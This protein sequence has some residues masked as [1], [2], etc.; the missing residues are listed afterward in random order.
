MLVLKLFK[1][2]DQS[3]RHDRGVDFD[4]E[5]FTVEVIRDIKRA[6]TLSGLQRTGYEIR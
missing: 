5:H 2:T 4:M 1:G 3:V 6:E